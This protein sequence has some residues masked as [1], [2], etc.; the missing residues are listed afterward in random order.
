[1]KL[2]VNKLR[3]V[4]SKLI[5]PNRD[6]FNRSKSLAFAAAVAIASLSISSQSASAY[7]LTNVVTASTAHPDSTTDQTGQSVSFTSFGNLNLPTNTNIPNGPYTSIVGD[8]VGTFTANGTSLSNGVTTSDSGNTV[9]AAFQYDSSGFRLIGEVTT[10]STGAYSQM[11]VIGVTPGGSV[12]GSEGR[13]SVNSTTTGILG[14]ETWLSTPT[15]PGAAT[16]TDTYLGIFNSSTEYSATTVA[17]PATTETASYQSGV[18]LAG[19]Y[20]VG[21]SAQYAGD[22]NSAIGQVLSQTLFHG[23]VVGTNYVANSTTVGQF[24]WIQ[25]AT[26][27]ATQIGLYGSGNNYAYS[28]PASLN[29]GVSTFIGTYYGEG[30]TGVNASGIAIGSAAAYSNVAAAPSTSLG[31]DVWMYNGT[32]TVPI[33]LYNSGQTITLPSYSGG[34]S[35]TYNFYASPTANVGTTSATSQYRSST[36]YFVNPSGVVAGVSSYYPRWRN[37]YLGSRLGCI[38]I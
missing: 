30:V 12:L 32:T 14:N 35:A 6:N 26:S 23:T 38:Y 13:S 25:T 2:E 28:T 15:A 37:K 4:D 20:A 27:A 10:S 11:N 29:G 21:T 1:M 36:L 8:A 31:T 18:A 24:A 16:A 17:F 7:T 22:G 34:P 5:H 33:G 19:A 9:Y 3:S